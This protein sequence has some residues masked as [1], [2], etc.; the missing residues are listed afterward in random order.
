MTLTD[1]DSIV[2]PW[3]MERVRDN[4]PMG[5]TGAIGV[6]DRGEMVAGVVFDHLTGVCVTATIAIDGKKLPRRMIRAM[7]NYPYKYLGVDKILVY[8]NEANKAS[9]KL[10][11]RLGF[12][13]E[14]VVEGVYADGSMF[15]LSLTKQDCIWIRS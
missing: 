12:T 9:T 15:I 6:L 1:D 11:K 8:V 10:A 14:A 3:V 2:A 4:F 13:I 7:F 5:I